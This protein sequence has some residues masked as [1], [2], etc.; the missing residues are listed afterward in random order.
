[1]AV[2]EPIRVAIA[3]DDVETLSAL[4]DLIDD[5]PLFE[6]VGVASDG[7]AIVDVV[8]TTQPRIVIMDV[9]MPGGGGVAATEAIKQ[10]FAGVSVIGLSTNGD[11]RTTRRMLEAGADRYLV[12]GRSDVLEELHSLAANF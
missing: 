5:D 7:S 6:V 4:R 10:R 3:D 1:M 11:V 9:V 8:G 2:G 12:K